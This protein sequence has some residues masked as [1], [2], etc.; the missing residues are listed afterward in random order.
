MQSKPISDLI[1]QLAD[2]LEEFWGADEACRS[3]TA[4]TQDQPMLPGAEDW[5]HEHRAELDFQLRQELARL[6]TLALPHDRRAAAGAALAL[7]SPRH[8]D[9]DNIVV[10]PARPDRFNDM[11]LRMPIAELCPTRTGQTL[12]E[13]LARVGIRDLNALVKEDGRARCRLVPFS[14]AEFEMLDELMARFGLRL[15]PGVVP[16]RLLPLAAER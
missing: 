10:L 13:K 11:V 14:E 16:Q 1:T 6:I 9:G 7:Q 12:A 15:S 8:L 4:T 5:P 3:A 2:T